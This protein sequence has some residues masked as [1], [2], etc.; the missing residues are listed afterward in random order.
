M[1]CLNSEQQQI[2]KTTQISHFFSQGKTLSKPK[3]NRPPASSVPAAAQL[4]QTYHKWR[5]GAMDLME[6]T[7]PVR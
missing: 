5:E 1:R 4:S 2:I 7:T 3:V 6:Q